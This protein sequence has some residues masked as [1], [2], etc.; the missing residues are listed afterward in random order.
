MIIASLLAIVGFQVLVMG[1]FTK[2][3]AV[4]SHLEGEDR[5]VAFVYKYLTLEKASFLGIVMILLGVALSFDI[6]YSWV[7][8]NFGSLFEVRR[9]I[10]SSTLIILGVQAIFSAFFLS[11]LAVPKK[12]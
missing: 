4:V 9:A 2:T 10:F 3:Y 8:S 12:E 6:I 1:F 5:L 7:L 11:L